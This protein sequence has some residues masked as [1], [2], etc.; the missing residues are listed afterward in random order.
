MAKLDQ[1]K[2]EFEHDMKLYQEDLTWITSLGDYSMSLKWAVKIN[3]LKESLDRA[4]ERVQSFVD[5]EKLFNIDVS[6]YSE[7]DVVIEQFEPFYRL[8]TT[9]IEFKYSEDEWLSAPV[10]RLDSEEIDAAVDQWFKDSYKMFKSF[11][12]QQIPQQVAADLREAIEAFKQNMPVIRALCQE[13]MQ[14]RHW[15]TLFEEIECDTDIDDALTLQQLLDIGILDHIETVENISAVAQKQFSLK[16]T[17]AGMKAEWKPM[18]FET[19]PYKE[20]GTYLM[21]GV[22]DIQV[23]LDDHI[24]KTQA[25][26]GS[27]FVK[28]I[29]KEVKDWEAKLIYIQDLLEQWLNSAIL[30]LP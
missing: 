10:A 22:D 4:K 14:P 26:R 9:A 6:D 18:E 7:L 21:K 2:A 20:T 13:A 3:G 16:S 19:M 29:E 5:R 25:V 1:E 17:L 24:V 12:G 27:P 11:D 30:A 8:W 15:V 23:L 28:P